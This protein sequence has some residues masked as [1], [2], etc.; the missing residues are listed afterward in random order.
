MGHIYINSGPVK[1]TQGLPRF[2]K[3]YEEIALKYINRKKNINICDYIA[4]LY[5]FM[6]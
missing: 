3:S 1:E 6:F 5:K 2:Y 4:Y